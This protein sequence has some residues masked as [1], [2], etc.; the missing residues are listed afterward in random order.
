MVENGGVDN[1][2]VVL[3]LKKMSATIRVRFSFYIFDRSDILAIIE[4]LHKVTLLKN[5]VLI[6]NALCEFQ[7]K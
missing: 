3:V 2:C 5:G 7:K 6:I 1:Q 4:T